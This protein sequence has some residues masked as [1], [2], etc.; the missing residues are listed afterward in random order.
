MFLPDF[1]GAILQ[2]CQK[3]VENLQFWRK[4]KKGG[5]HKGMG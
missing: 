1:A 4:D 3:N 5:G 2:N